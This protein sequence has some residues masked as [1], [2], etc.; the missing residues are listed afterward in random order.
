MLI[1]AR[2]VLRLPPFD[3][4]QLCHAMFGRLITPL[5]A[6][7]EQS[8]RPEIQEDVVQDEDAS[9]EDF[10]RDVLVELMRNAVEKLK[11]AEDIKDKIEV[12]IC[13]RIILNMSELFRS[14]ARCIESC[15]RMHVRKMYSASS[16]V[17][18]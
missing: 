8:I 14:W 17:S 9:A 3:P 11:E 1:V 6:R 7:F 18:C 5:R 10:A 13:G 16:M 2:S 12:R 4:N 15:W